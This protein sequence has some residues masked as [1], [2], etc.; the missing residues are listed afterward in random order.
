M[1]RFL[2]P[3]LLASL[4]FGASSGVLTATPARIYVSFVSHNEES[5]SNPPCA[6]VLTD[7]VRYL[8]NRA[9]V[10]SLA[11]TIVDRGATWDFQSEWE[12]L[13]KVASWD[14][15][16]AR[17]TTGGQNIVEYLS[18]LAPSQLVVDAHSHQLRGYNYADVAYMLEQLG[19]PA[20][21]IVGGFI[22]TPASRAN[23]TVFRRPLAGQRYP[24]A[25]FTATALWGG[26]SVNHRSDSN[27]SGI[28]RPKSV[29]QFHTDDPRQTLPVIG[30]YTGD[31][32]SADGVLDLLERLRRNEL[33]PNHMYTA[34]I[35]L[36][37]C[38]LDSDPGIAQSAEDII[39]ALEDAVRDGEVVWATLPEMLRVWQDEYGSTPTI[40]LP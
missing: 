23:W 13:T 30:H 21:G 32:A 40:F 20:T 10:V 26:G 17:A 18:Q 7:R 11:S 36:P 33:Q 38:E 22:A 39:A 27:A 1:K 4:V 3:T 29:F 19:V 14:D 5:I 8:T 12:Y 24:A 34:T 15:A 9:A 31:V 16:D 2:I 25:T 28:W 37:Q 35:M 6:P